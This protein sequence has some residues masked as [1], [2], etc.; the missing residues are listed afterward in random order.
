MIWMVKG[1]S[2]YAFVRVQNMLESFRKDNSSRLIR[3]YIYV[4]NSCSHINELRSE[5][6]LYAWKRAALGQYVVTRSIGFFAESFKNKKA[7]TVPKTWCFLLILYS[8]YRFS[9][10]GF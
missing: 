5:D 7:F 10:G 2:L 4:S 9:W 8:R 1:V 3:D 6:L